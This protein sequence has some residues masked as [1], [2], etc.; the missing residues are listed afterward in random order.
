M[1]NAAVIPD[2]AGQRR[3]R[4]VLVAS[5]FVGSLL[6]YAITC[7]P[8]LLWQDSA[9]F[10]YRVL[11]FNLA[12]DIGLPLAHPLYIVLA[13]PLAL[14]PLGD[15]AFRVNL[16]SALCGAVAIALLADLL[17]LLTRNAWAAVIGAVSLAVSHTFWTHSVIAEVYNLYTVGLFAELW[18]AFRFF[19]TKK[20]KW[21]MLA[22]LVNGLNLSNHLMAILHWPAYLGVLY[23]GF[24]Q[25]AVKPAHV[26]PILAALA[27]GSSLYL[28]LIAVEL[29][30]GRPALEVFREALVGPPHRAKH[31]LE[32]SFPWG[33]QI[34]NSVM[35]FGLNFPTPLILLAP[36]GFAFAWRQPSLALLA[37]FVGA[38]FVIAFVFAFRYTVPDQFAF[39]TP[40]YALVALFI[41]L[42]AGSFAGQSKG[43]CVLCVALAVLPIVVYEAAPPLLRQRG[44]SIGLSREI[45]Y[46]DNYDYFIR[47]RKNGFHGTERY[48]RE[49]LEQAG[50]DGLIYADTTI[51]NGLIFARDIWQ[52]QPEVILLGA[53]DILPDPPRMEGT[54]ATL[55]PYVDQRRAWSVVPDSGYVPKWIRAEFTTEPDGLLYRIVPRP[56]GTN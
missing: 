23:W 32:Y 15:I 22:A 54:A 26:V 47:P 48:A 39:F 8:G 10:Q 6:L 27:L 7:A 1:A 12:G 31:V 30:S 46:R 19:Q 38:V 13:K 21:L 14:L 43:R 9:M 24:R 45:A 52:L 42:G 17:I 36:V 28:Y 29:G 4:I 5:C 20:L 35:Y 44:I 11:R 50:P 41:G 55:R 2:E 33:R 40:G 37:R 51:I 25:R 49:A 18:L 53:G 3:V 34:R 16:F 56:A